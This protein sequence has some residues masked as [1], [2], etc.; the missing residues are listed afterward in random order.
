MSRAYLHEVSEFVINLVPLEAARKTVA[1]I[2]GFKSRI[3]PAIKS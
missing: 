1:A 3:K 2:N